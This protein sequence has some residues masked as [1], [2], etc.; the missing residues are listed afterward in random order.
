MTVRVSSRWSGWRVVILLVGLVYPRQTGAQQAGQG[1]SGATTLLVPQ[2]A[3]RSL[4]REVAFERATLDY[5]AGHYSRCVSAFRTLLA[6]EGAA[7][8]LPAEER[9]AVH[10]YL[11]A[12]LVASNRREEAREQFRL[13]ILENRH[14]TAPDPIVFPRS[15]VDLFVEVRTQLMG[16]LRRQQEEEL[17][18]DREKVEERNRQ[19][20][21][22]RLRLEEL[23]RL[24]ATETVVQRNERWMAWIPFGVGQFHNG[25][26]RLGWALLGTE[27]VLGISALAATSVELGLHA[28]GKGGNSD[29]DTVALNRAIRS[30]HTISTA[31]WISLLA[32]MSLG[33]VEANWS[34][35]AEVPL[36]I[37]PR[38]VPPSNPA[39]SGS[40]APFSGQGAEGRA[41]GQVVEH[42]IGLEGTF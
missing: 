6:R 19:R 40:L 24:V 38:V 39:R 4:G 28:Q 21:R 3:T 35:R 23:E 2:E 42:W 13:A 27:A 17:R 22:D 25:D 37:R 18:R 31:S 20:D 30:A 16:T 14:M 10:T 1:E 15:V 29:L 41:P 32:V 12:C 26:D 34:Y 11:S 8:V 9:A 7:L 36:G 33:L 5:E